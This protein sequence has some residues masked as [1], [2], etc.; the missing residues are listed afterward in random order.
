V[1]HGSYEGLGSA[2]GEFIGWITTEGHKSAPDLRGVL[3]R[4]PRVEP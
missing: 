2:W 1:Y 4:G 3:R